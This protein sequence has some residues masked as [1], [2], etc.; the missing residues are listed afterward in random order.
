[1]SG[2]SWNDYITNQL[3]G[4]GNVTK[5]AIAG[6]DGS[7]WAISDGWG[8]TQQECQSIANGFTNKDGLV[9]SGMMCAGEKY[10]FLS[11]DDGVLRGK[12]GNKGIHVAKTNTALVI[13]Q[14]E[15]P[16]QPGQCAATV[17]ALADY[18]KNCNY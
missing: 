13:G 7:V 5:G 17:E 3:T 1:M 4:T 8:V 9:Q 10:F 15:D 18:L 2:M 14:Y 6:L 12:K 11:G 16:I